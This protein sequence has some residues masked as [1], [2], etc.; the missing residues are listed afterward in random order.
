[1]LSRGLCS[2]IGGMEQGLAVQ[3]QVFRCESVFRRAVL[4]ENRKAN[5]ENLTLREAP[6]R[7]V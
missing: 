1:M 7:T 2:I 3:R 6:L 5:F 4:R